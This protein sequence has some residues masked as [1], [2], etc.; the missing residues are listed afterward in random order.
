MADF[1]LEIG[2]EEMP[3]RFVP[4]LG[5]DI[6]NIFSD[7]LKEH[8]IDFAEVAAFATPRRLSVFVTDIALDQRKVEEEVS[9]PP[10]RIAYDADGKPTKACDGFVKSQ[11]IKPEDIY[12]IKTDKGDYLGAKKTVGGAATVSILPEM[13]ITAIKKLSFPKKMKWGSLEFTFGRPLRWLLC[14]C[15]DQVVDFEL[16]GLTSGRKTYG[17]RVMGAGPWDI[18]SASDYFNTIEQKCSVVISPEK[19]GEL[20]RAEGDKLASALNGSVVWKDSLLQEVSNL[21]EF[22][23]PIIGNFEE[24]FLELPKEVLLTSMESHQKCFGIENSDG[25]LLPHFLC[26]LNLKP[27]EM[28]LVRKGWEKVLKA[29]LE[30]ARFFW[31]KDLDTDF[32]V[33][34]EKLEH[35][36]FLGPLGTMGDKSRRLENL[37]ALIAGKVDPDLQTEMARAGKIA[38]ADLVSEMVNEFDKLQGLMGGIYGFKKGEDDVVCKAISEQYLPAGPES[39]VPSTIGGAII[40]MTDK[41]D[42]LVGCFGLNKIPTGANDAYALRRAALG[43]IRM[44]LEFRL[45][46]D[47]LEIFDMAY[48]GYSK[49]IKWKLDK[50]EILE[51][52]GDFISSRLRAYFT[53]QGY[54][55]RV[56]DAALG[57]GFRDVN[58]LKARVEALSEFAKEEGFE[59]SVLT[60]KRASNIIRKQG[61]EAGLILTGGYEVEKLIEPQEKD[62][63]KKLDDT[64]DRFEELWGNDDFTNL[65]GILGELRPFVDDFFDNVMVISDD[66]SLKI[67]RLN[68][69]QALVDR[70]SRLA[71][72][73]A[74]QV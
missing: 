20:V 52:L 53:G 7:L 38:K 36:V 74:L 56:V 55:T 49:D 45:S 13:C 14:L 19:R 24:S 33:W 16:A 15:G 70:L 17:H 29:R 69:L 34:L 40:S 60:F 63:A 59:Q 12:L 57:A 26:T 51:K 30:D 73:G 61:S 68:L 71:D 72:F 28:D 3:A 64:A 62:L 43:I 65:F 46:V 44:I 22:P 39:P 4:R 50:A 37:A 54:E 10:A 41:A 5:E 21:V 23:M 48:D 32:G 9:G 6:K 25:N 58:A 47:I 66:E 42:T 8:M 35:V 31:A 11:G 67:N 27:K 1:I 2:I 18:A